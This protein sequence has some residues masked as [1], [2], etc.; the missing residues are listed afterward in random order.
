MINATK[1]QH[2]IWDWN[3][4]LL[5]DAWLFVDIM[6][7]IL[8]QHDMEMITIKKYRDIFGFPIT[9][10]TVVSTLQWERFPCVM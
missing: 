5:N 6:N 1:Y 4:T 8:K 10:S 9:I 3:G 7:G 2:I